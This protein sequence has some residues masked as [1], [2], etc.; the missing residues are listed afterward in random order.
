MALPT[1]T[2]DATSLLRATL[3]EA[4]LAVG[5][6]YANRPLACSPDGSLVA[7][8]SGRHVWVA[9]ASDGVVIHRFHG[10]SLEVVTAL[11]SLDSAT[12]Y[13]VGDRAVVAWNIADGTPRFVVEQTLAHPFA[14]LS[15]DGSRLV[16]D[17]TRELIAIDTSTGAIC[18][19][20]P[21]PKPSVGAYPRF[22]ADGE[23]L[24]LLGHGVLRVDRDLRVT[25]EI[26][27]DRE[28]KHA[29]SVGPSK[30]VAAASARSLLL[31]DLADARVIAR[32]EIPGEVHALIA[33]GD[34]L[35]VLHAKAPGAYEWSLTAHD[36][37]TL[38][39][40][41]GAARMSLPHLVSVGA[42]GDTLWIEGS[43]SLVRRS[44]SSGGDLRDAFAMRGECTALRFDARAE[45]LCASMGMYSTRV[46]VMRLSLSSSERVALDFNHVTALAFTR[47]CDAAI[48]KSHPAG[49][50]R[51]TFGASPEGDP[52]DAEGGFQTVYAAGPQGRLIA[53]DTAALR[54]L[55]EGARWPLPPKH[56]LGYMAEWHVDEELV[57]AHDLKRVT[58]FD[59][60]EGVYLEPLKMPSYR[61]LC[62]VPG[63][64]WIT[65]DK[66]AQLWDL[67]ARKRLREVPFDMPQWSVATSIA[68]SRDGRLLAVGTSLGAV[69]LKE[70]DGAERT[71][72]FQTEGDG[73]VSACEFSDDGAL[74]ATG[75]SDP[76]VRV[77]DVAR[78]L[79]AASP[80]TK[81]AKKKR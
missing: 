30:R 75:C 48:V 23:H 27:P 16:I 28:F 2:Q 62:W 81:P 76:V 49:A 38:R 52:I 43:G 37:S 7:G 9:R 54:V 57:S 11:F 56:K 64:A 40:L 6:S 47:D 42:S 26:E 44:L 53:I 80:V 36:A 65:T 67:R 50:R 5:R 35:W 69:I 18:A 13:T 34:A 55:P 24:A 78:A 20:A 74:L 3:G 71:V 60:R 32:E 10:R 8:I 59:L 19:T 39:P 17:A 46:S 4:P 61:K 79:D 31:I 21:R 33:R 45:R 72:V 70:L 77:W 73:I 63:G 58:L 1:V 29:C 25:A 51:Y 66:R 12:L 14:T 15:P 22:T 68:A 41:E